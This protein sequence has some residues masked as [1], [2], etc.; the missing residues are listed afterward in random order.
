[1]SGAVANYSS[2]GNSSSFCSAMVSGQLFL[3]WC[4]DS[5]MAYRGLTTAVAPHWHV[6]LFTLPT[7]FG[8]APPAAFGSDGQPVGRVQVL[9][10][11]HACMCLLPHR[12][13]L[14][15]CVCL[16][17]CDAD[18]DA[19]FS[20]DCRRASAIY[21]CRSLSALDKWRVVKLMR[22]VRPK[23]MQRLVAMPPGTS[24]SAV[25]AV[26]GG[27]QGE[28]CGKQAAGKL[29]VG[30]QWAGKQQLASCSRD[31]RHEHTQACQACA[32]VQAEP[33]LALCMGG[34]RGPAC[35][36]QVTAS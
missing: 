5:K 20:I 7:A 10:C 27:G 4:M 28:V 23:W 25:C 29:G 9:A 26:M 6:R 14:P 13:A 17:W 12:A 3:L 1:M 32:L 33:H 15:A 8:L 24:V 2:S 16:C 18:R 31:G 30:V 34:Y 11:L 35:R 19:P 36:A 22:C 21:A